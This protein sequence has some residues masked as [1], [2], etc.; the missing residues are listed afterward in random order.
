M[1]YSRCSFTTKFISKVSKSYQKRKQ[2]TKKKVKQI[3]FF[4]FK[5]PSHVRFMTS[6]PLTFYIFPTYDPSLLLTFT[7]LLTLT[8]GDLGSYSPNR[9]RCLFY[10]I[11]F[12]FH[13]KWR[14]EKREAREILDNISLHRH[15]HSASPNRCSTL[16]RS[17]FF[18]SKGKKYERKIHFFPFGPILSYITFKKKH[19]RDA[20]ISVILLVLN[21]IPL[22]MSPVLSRIQNYL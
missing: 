12:F 5:N 6:S 11:F 13:R 3:S 15:L 8:T 20:Q 1:V 7:I 21:P 9:S 22:G 14:T 17:P 2:R 10:F 16:L 19:T 4:T 18:R